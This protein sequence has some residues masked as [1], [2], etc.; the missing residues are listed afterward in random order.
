MYIKN[1]NKYI[2]NHPIDY[3]FKII[4]FLQLNFGQ[5]PMNLNYDRIS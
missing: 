2:H 5:A 4:F 3:N 1:K